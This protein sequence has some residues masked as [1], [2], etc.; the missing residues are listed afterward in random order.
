[1]ATFEMTSNRG[2]SGFPAGYGSGFNTQYQGV[3][4]YQ[5]PRP[6]QPQ[7]QGSNAGSSLQ[8]YLQQLM[9]GGGATGAGTR[10]APTQRTVGNPNSTYVGKARGG[11]GVRSPAPAATGPDWRSILGSQ[12]PGANVPPATTNPQTPVNDF[13]T[14]L[15]QMLAAYTNP[16]TAG[17]LSNDAIGQAQGTISAAAP[18]WAVAKYGGNFQD[19]MNQD[20][21]R[22]AINL[23]R[24]ASEQQAAM[25]LSHQKAKAGAGLDM[26]G[27]LQQLNSQNV[28]HQINSQDQMLRSM[29]GLLGGLA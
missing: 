12:Y 2:I 24:A 20:A 22:A 5:M 23:S 11:R 25:D 16:I 21:G 18:A 9:G 4:A 13:A 28:T 3:N 7:Q 6:Q 27:L 19:N 17:Q 15:Q 29:L 10:K 14:Q 26:A 8:A 1:M